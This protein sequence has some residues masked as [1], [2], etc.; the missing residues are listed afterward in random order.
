MPARSAPKTAMKVENM[1]GARND[2]A[3]PVVVYRPK[4]TPS[5]PSADIR[6]ISVRAADS[7]GPMNRHSISPQ[8]QNARTPDDVMR[9]RPTTIIAV[10]APTMT[11]LAPNRSSSTPPMTAP[12]AAMMLALTPNSITSSSAMP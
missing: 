6:S 3:R 2:T 12:M 7:D 9:M 8:I 1:T 11:G 10:S 4:A 5:L